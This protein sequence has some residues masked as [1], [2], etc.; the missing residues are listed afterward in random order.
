MSNAPFITVTSGA[1]GI[2]A[3]VVSLSIAANPGAARSGKVAIADQ[4]VTVNQLAFGAVFCA[5]SVSPSYIKTS[6]AATTATATVTVALG[7][8]TCA[9]TAQ[10]QSP[11]FVSII[12]GSSGV[13]NGTVTLGIG[14]N[15]GPSRNGGALIG[16]VNVIVD[17]A[18]PSAAN[19]LQPADRGIRIRRRW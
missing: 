5:F 18:P 14:A 16:G 6:A 1:S 4:Q 15:T 11:E 12:S 9:W 17:Q 7:P 19:L 2:N 8:Q 10:T 13:G 3:G